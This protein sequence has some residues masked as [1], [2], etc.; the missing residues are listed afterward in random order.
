M[1]NFS[2]YGTLLVGPLIS[3]GY[4]LGDL[5]MNR[6]GRRI[7]KRYHI[8]RNFSGVC[9]AT[10]NLNLVVVILARMRRYRKYIHFL[11][12]DAQTDMLEILTCFRRG[13]LHVCPF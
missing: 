6:K 5:W 1:M 7:M 3:K 2:E 8:D 12:I 4:I 10:F 13:Y 9:R 11:D